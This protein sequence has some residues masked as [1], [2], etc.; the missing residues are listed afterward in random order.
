[1][2]QTVLKW[3]LGLLT[4]ILITGATALGSSLNADIKANATAIAKLREEQKTIEIQNAH[5]EEQLAH[6][7]RDINRILTILERKQ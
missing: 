2:Q 6:L 7:S 1:M 5:I 4:A 3:A